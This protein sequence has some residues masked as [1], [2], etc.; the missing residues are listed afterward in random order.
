MGDLSVSLSPFGRELRRWRHARGMS[1]LDLALEAETSA[2]HMSFIETG[3]AQ[4]SRVMVLRLAETLGLPLRDRNRLL[5]AAGYISAFK[6]TPIEDAT[7]SQVR[8]ALEF[9]LSHHE[10]YPAMVVNRYWDLLVANRSAARLMAQLGI[11]VLDSR[12][13]VNLLRLLLNPDQ[14]RRYVVDWEEAA[15]GLIVRAQQEF[16]APPPDDTASA[17]LTELLGYPGVPRSWCEPRFDQDALP[18]CSMSFEKDGLRTS[19]FS[20]IATFGTPRDITLQELRIESFFPADD[21]TEEMARR[22]ATTE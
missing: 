20:T 5:N 2:R 10:P 4:P 16:R 17:L 7:M 19:W 18:V 15:R 14:L 3:R 12:E 21:A 9:T 13:T 6:E 1:Q 22:L 11:D 8:R